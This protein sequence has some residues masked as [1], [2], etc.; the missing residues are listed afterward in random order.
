MSYML[1]SA[2]SFLLLLHVEN[3]IKLY[4]VVAYLNKV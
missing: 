4:K 3:H 2:F 1:L